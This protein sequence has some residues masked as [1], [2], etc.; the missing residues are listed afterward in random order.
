MKSSD[1]EGNFVSF[2]GRG[3]VSEFTQVLAVGKNPLDTLQKTIDGLILKPSS[4]SSSALVTNMRILD[5]V[6][7]PRLPAEIHTKHVL[8]KLVTLDLHVD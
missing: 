8:N 1:C 2:D 7:L 6:R 3:S 4:G 5:N